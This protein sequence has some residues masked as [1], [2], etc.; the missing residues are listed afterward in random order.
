MINLKKGDAPISLTKGSGI[1][2]NCSWDSNTDYDLYA[3]I[4]YTDGS[5]DTVAT[6]GARGVPKKEKSNDGAVIHGGDVGRGI[7]GQAQETINVTLNDNIRAVVPVCYS[8][9]SNGV[10]SFR[11]YMVSMMVS[12]G[13][14]QTVRVDA[15]NASSHGNVYTCVPGWIENTPSGALVHYLESYS[16]PGS[17]N[18]PIVSFG[19]EKKGLFG[20]STATD[21][22][23]IVMDAGPRNN[24]K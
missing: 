9:Q 10:G 7:N 22:V 18:R 16:R 11:Q 6:F 8:A 24:H 23:Q 21:K 19:K 15:D 20:K 13:A 4:L 17:E 14:G 3:L 1:V 12:D 5:M 2:L